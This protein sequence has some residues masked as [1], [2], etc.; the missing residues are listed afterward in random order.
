[1]T[2][3]YSQP[4]VNSW[5]TTPASNVQSRR[6]VV[7]VQM[8]IRILGLRPSTGVAKLALLVPLPSLLMIL[9]G[10]PT[11]GLHS[12]LCVE[13]NTIVA[14]TALSVVVYF[15][16]TSRLRESEGVQKIMV[17]VGS[18]EKLRD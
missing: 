14:L 17:R 5:M 7:Y 18:V 11:V 3:Y 13:D 12:L 2:L 9:A 10:I 15:E 16:V 1:M 8:Y 4:W 6:G